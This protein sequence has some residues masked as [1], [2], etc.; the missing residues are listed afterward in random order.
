LDGEEVRQHLGNTL[1][2]DRE[3]RIL[4]NYYMAYLSQILNRNGII[5]VVAAIAPYRETRKG[6][7][8]II[9]DSFIEVYCRCPLSVLKV[10]DK[11]GLYKKAI[12]GEL[13]DFTGVSDPYEEPLNPE[14]ILETDRETPEESLGKICQ[15]LEKNWHIQGLKPSPDGYSEEEEKILEERLKNFGY[16]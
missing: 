2:F 6:L 12:A 1:G 4:H 16:L 11:K 7:R 8:R 9:G 13:K 10:R 5:T 15:Y 3:A 14:L